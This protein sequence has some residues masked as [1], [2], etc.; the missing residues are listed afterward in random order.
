MLG[1]IAVLPLFAEHFWEKNR[2]K[3]IVSLVLGIPTAL[4]MLL[5]GASHEVVHSVVFDYIPFIILLGGLYI[6]SGGIFIDADVSATPRNNTLIMLIGAVLASLIGTTGAAMLLIRLLLNSNKERKHKVHTVLFFI[7]IVA[8]CG[9]LLTPLGD[10]P[11]FMMYLR[12]ADFFWFTS[13]FKEWIFVNG[14]LLVVYFIYDSMMYKK[15]SQEDI[16]LD[17]KE[18]E[19]LKIHGKLNFLW[20]FMIIAAVAFINGNVLPFMNE[21]P[22]Y[23]FLRDVVIV[24]AAVMSLITTKKET[25]TEN[26][27]SW[28]PITEV[29]YLFFGIFLTMVPVIMLLQENAQALGIVSTTQFYYFTGAL[30]SVLDNTPTAVTFHAL[31]QGGVS[32]GIFHDLLAGNPTMVAGVPEI[33]LK[34][35]SVAAVCFG[36]LTY[37]GNGPNFMVKAIAEQAGVKMPQFFAYCIKFS[38]II[39]LPILILC[40][41]IFF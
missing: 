10:P 29:A 13:L 24:I 36:S 20:L 32:Q 14:L 17:I 22:V 16:E 37:I 28:E 7:G 19:P 34:V 25:R 4:Y 31:A 3:L 27:F 41:L 1:C 11:L 18:Y 15:E 6:V 21:N 38:L 30:S 40:N 2:N 5:H 9:G 33:I 8:N 23:G 26:N 12:G 35:I 39:I